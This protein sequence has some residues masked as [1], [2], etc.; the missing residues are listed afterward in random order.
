MRY[1]D[2]Q[3]SK[4]CEGL[5]APEAAEQ[6]DRPRLITME[7]AK[8]LTG[9]PEVTIAKWIQ[10]GLIFETEDGR[11]SETDLMQ[12]HRTRRRVTNRRKKPDGND[13][14]DGKA[15]EDRV[16]VK[17]NMTTPSGMVIEYEGTTEGASK[18]IDMFVA[19]G[20]ASGD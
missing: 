16:P 9:R 7:E 14:E 5:I 20:L 4:D 6:Q 12:Q 8:R 3:T 1:D 19:A 13:S 10:G 15:S 18:I 11:I 2:E 17:L